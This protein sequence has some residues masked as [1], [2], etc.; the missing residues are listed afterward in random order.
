MSPSPD[1]QST[2]TDTLP[3]RREPPRPIIGY[4]HA[5]LLTMLRRL[6]E[7]VRYRRLARQYA[8]AFREWEESGDAEV[9]DL[10]VADGLEDGD[11]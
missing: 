4:D 3:S 11:W 1:T 6:R 5:V 10:A 8:E 2:P 9:W 7:R